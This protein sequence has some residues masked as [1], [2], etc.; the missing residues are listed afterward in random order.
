MS[1]FRHS[2]RPIFGIFALLVALVGS[3][4]PT[5]AG[6]N[7]GHKSAEKVQTLIAPINAEDLK[8]VVDQLSD[9]IVYKNTGLPSFS[10]KPAVQAFLTPVFFCALQCPI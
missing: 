1:R 8:G 5:H 9:D 6:H 7:A 2:I 4:G 10:G 3:I